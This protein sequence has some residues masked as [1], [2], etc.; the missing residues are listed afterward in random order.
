VPH[1]DH[2][3]FFR[4][5]FVDWRGPLNLIL[6]PR[7]VKHGLIFGIQNND[8]DEDQRKEIWLKMGCSC[9]VVRRVESAPCRRTS[10][11][12]VGLPLALQ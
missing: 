9:A 2:L 12:W 4:G 7:I 1:R 10:G 6:L 8:A 3:L 5:A 11:V